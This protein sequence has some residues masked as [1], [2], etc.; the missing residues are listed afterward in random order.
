MVLPGDWDGGPSCVLTGRQ[1]RRLSAVLRLAPGDSFPAIGQD[2]RPYECTIV[3]L[4][5]DSVSLSLVPAARASAVDYRPDVRAG[6]PGAGAAGTLR[7]AAPLPRLILAVGLLK[8]S[9]LD[10][11]VRAA[12]EAGVE[13]VL[14]LATARSLPKDQA[15]GRLDRL[16]RIAAEALEQSGS[17]VP[18]KILEPMS[19]AELVLAM[20]PS[21]GARLGLF[22]HETPLAQASLHRYCTD[23]ADEIIACVGPE[24]GFSIDE[25]GTLSEGGFKPAWL[26]PA[27][28][29]AE[30]AAAFAIASLRTICLERSA[31]SM[32][33]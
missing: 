10:D 6:R 11:V 12:A 16:R 4:G 5:R 25:L 14:P 21:P 3:G 9:K 13:A 8:G 29:R 26:G 19:V 1:A 20:P 32:T 22:F 31:W 15:G 27:V 7:E 24:G 30:T 33:E 18:T 17:A 28:L 2:G 23:V